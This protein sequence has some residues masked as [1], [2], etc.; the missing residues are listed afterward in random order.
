[1]SQTSNTT[2][3]TRDAGTRK[4]EW[5]PPGK[6]DVPEPPA[7]MKY[8]W[9][10]HELMGEDQS[11]NVYQWSRQGYEPVKANELG[12]FLTDKME[13]GK[14]DGVI[15]SGDLILTKVPIE[16]AE[17]RIGYFEG[18]AKRLQ[19]AVDMELSKEDS[20][21]MPIERESSTS[22][23]R[24]SSSRNEQEFEDQYTV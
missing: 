16:I 4:K 12:D 7:G 24:G 18:Q 8:R 20:Q 1:M 2:R 13:G 11:A 3:S 22:V 9:V 15:R 6:L 10:R 5:R 19:Q 17:Q 14:H 23:T 21:A